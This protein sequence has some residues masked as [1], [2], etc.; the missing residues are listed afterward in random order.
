MMLQEILS[1]LEQEIPTSKVFGFTIQKLTDSEAQC[2]MPLEPNINHK[3]TMFGGSQYGGCALACYAL[4]LHNVRAT[5]CRTNDIVISHGEMDY[6][7]PAGEDVQIEAFWENFEDRE[8]FLDHLSRKGKARV[9]LG[10][11]VRGSKGL[12]LSEFRGDFVVFQKK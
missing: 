12:L 3:G 7:K 6:F 11:R 10:A 8:K 4:F 9:R 2:F 5:D 1:Q